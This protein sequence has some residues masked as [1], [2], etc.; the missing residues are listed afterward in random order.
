MIGSVFLVGDTLF[1]D[2]VLTSVLVA[3]GFVDG[4]V[5]LGQ[6][7]GIAALPC[8]APSAMQAAHLVGI[9][10]SE[11]NLLT[12]GQRQNAALVLQQ[13]LRLFSC[14][15]RFLGKLIATELLVALSAGVGLV[16]Q[17][18]AVF[19]AQ[20]AAHSIVDALHAHL[21]FL[22]QFLQQDAELHA[23]GIHRHV[24]TGIDGNADGVFLVFCHMFAREEVIDV[25]PVGH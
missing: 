16:E 8:V 20:D 23:I 15:Q 14:L 17:V 12:F 5:L 9:G 11:Q 25:G 18:Q 13:N 7:F 24:D 1:E 6:V 3:E 19:H 22:H 21:A 4:V 2:D 10:T